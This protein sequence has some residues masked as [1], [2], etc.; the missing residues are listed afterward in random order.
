MGSMLPNRAELYAQLRARNEKRWGTERLDVVQTFGRDLRATV[1]DMI[2]ELI[3]NAEDADAQGLFFRLYENGLLVWNDGACFSDK[4]VE[5]ISGLLISNKDARS[6]GYFGIGFKSVLLVTQTPCVLSGS[7]AFRLDWALDPYPLDSGSPLPPEAWDLFQTGK[8]VFWLPFRDPPSHCASQVSRVF[9]LDLAELL[10][11]MH[12]LKEIRWE[13]PTAQ[14]RC[15]STPEVI[16][17]EERATSQEIRI[18]FQESQERK[19]AYESRWLRLD[20]QVE[21]PEPVIRNIVARLESEG[22]MKGGS[23]WKSLSPDARWQTF[24]VAVSLDEKGRLHPVEGRAFARLPTGYRTGLK[25]HVSGRFATTVDRDR[26]QEDDPLTQWAVTETKQLLAQMPEHLKRLGRFT[27]PMWAIFPAGK[28]AQSLFTP[29][30]DALRKALSEGE[31]FHGDDG[32]FYPPTDVYLAH[33]RELYNL[34]SNAALRE[35]TGNPKARWVHSELREGEPRD[36]VRSLGV[37]S[38]EPSHVLRWLQS[39]DAAWFEARSD[40]WLERLYR[41]LAGH[42]ELRTA[43]KGL[44]AVR[45]HTRRCVRPGEALRPPERFPEAL[46][47][48]AR[49]LPLVDSSICQDEETA[50]ALQR[51]GVREFDIGRALDCLLQAMYGGEDR[52]PAEE[53]R[54]HIR[55]LFVLWDQGELPVRTLQNRSSLPILRT[56]TGAYIPPNQAYLPAGLGGLK[57]VEEYFRLAGTDLF[58]AEDYAQQEDKRERWSEFLEILGT[59]RLPRTKTSVF[60]WLGGEKE[61]LQEWLANRNMVNDRRERAVYSSRTRRFR[62]I[63]TEIDGFEQVL[64]KVQEADDLDAVQA[65]YLTIEALVENGP[66]LDKDTLEY[67]SYY[68]DYSGYWH[69][70]YVSPAIWLSN[71]QTIPWLPDETGT[72]SIP[73]RLFH[74]D[75]KPILGPGFSYV[76]ERV[77]IR[78]G[79]KL[80]QLLGIRQEASVED[81]LKYLAELSDGKVDEAGI[82][83]PIYEWLSRRPSQEAH[84]IRQK[85]YEHALILMPEEGWFRSSEVCWRDRT[86]TVPE[87]SEHW[88]DLRS[89]FLDTVQIRES[90]RPDQLAYVL[91]GWAEREPGPDLSRIQKLA[92]ALSEQWDELSADLQRRL[93]TELC[94]PAKVG[95]GLRWERAS[96]IYLR[97]QEHIA[98]L[99]GN[100]LPWW[101]LDGLD[102]LAEKL[103]IFRISAAQQSVRRI[104]SPRPDHTL[105][106]HLERIWPFIVRFVQKHNLT[107]AAPKVQRVTRIEVR[108]RAGYQFSDPDAVQSHLCREEWCL[109]LSEEIGRHPGRYIGDALKRELGVQS[110]REFVR[111][112]LDHL[113]SSADLKETLQF[114]ERERDVCLTDLLPVVPPATPERIVGSEIQ[115]ARPPDVEAGFPLRAKPPVALASPGWVGLHE[116]TRTRDTGRKAEE[117]YPQHPRG[118]DAAERVLQGIESVRKDQI[119]EEAM[120]RAVKWWEEQG[121]E[122]RDVSSATRLGYDLEVTRGYV[123]YYVEVKGTEQGERI[124]IT[125]NEWEVAR[126][127]DEQYCLQVVVVPEGDIYLIWSP[128][129]TLANRVSQRERT[130]VQVYY[131]IPFSAILRLAKEG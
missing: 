85:F 33:S 68:D 61:A 46:K 10:L 26:L 48:Y 6:I 120:K 14:A 21:I 124:L 78:R 118:S 83:R 47:S 24:S 34:L 60:D 63:Q 97:D 95:D 41:Y 66:D 123:M 27:P 42:E 67:H 9:D 22:D 52:P 8:T 110:L 125:E 65:F 43:S 76:H 51:L 13:S 36:V 130:V 117:G 75:L 101:V 96:R 57:E 39:K 129:T 28:G 109:Y 121:F 38:V 106:H 111:D 94:W 4:D 40:K 50:E 45:L 7:H 69:K 89:F 98:R 86:G 11:F 72:P 35:V 53:N 107:D 128:A 99:F 73:N 102:D 116:E 87:V 108:Y 64:E 55:M 104:G 93:K 127:K 103:G 23:R 3:Q 5:S 131:E 114:W 62:A 100:A 58:V 1:R 80:A 92:S 70:L 20:W 90:P 18:R 81:V 17:Q 82:V 2:L 12:S 91:L 59:A 115:H 29:A 77:G 19:K 88:L 119:A 56:R 32:N 16:S 31:Y 54:E 25:F 113:E 126:E 71:L 37:L 112:M 49:Y 105:T 15:T 30:V 74:P 122:V 84:L 79:S 44:P